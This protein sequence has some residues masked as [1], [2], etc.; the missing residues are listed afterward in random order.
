MTVITPLFRE[1]VIK[2]DFKI[3]PRIVEK[4]LSWKWTIHHNTAI[5]IL[6]EVQEV[7]WEKHTLKDLFYLNELKWYESEQVVIVK[8][9]E[10]MTDEDYISIVRYMIE[11]KWE[12]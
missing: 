3:D 7:R 8:W 11:G 5:K 12:P 2:Y 4:L 1:I 10:K 9:M 6:K